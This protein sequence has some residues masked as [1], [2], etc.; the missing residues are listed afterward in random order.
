[1]SKITDVLEKGAVLVPSTSGFDLSSE[2]LFTAMCSDLVPVFIAQTLPNDRWS[3]GLLSQ[4]K[5]PPLATDFFGRVDINFE[6]FFVPYRLCYGG[7]EEFF[8]MP[9]LQHE[10]DTNH[11]GFRNP[12]DNVAG[13]AF[14]VGTMA[15]AD[16]SNGAIERN[17]SNNIDSQ[18]GNIAI[19]FRDANRLAVPDSVRPS[20][21]VN[22]VYNTLPKGTVTAADAGPGTLTDFM[23]AKISGTSITQMNIYNVLPYVAYHKIY[24]DYYRNSQYEN[25]AFVKPSNGTLSVEFKS[26]PYERFTTAQTINLSTS[27]CAD[28]WLVTKFRQRKWADDYFTTATPTPRGLANG[29]DVTIKTGTGASVSGSTVTPYNTGFTVPML[30]VANSLQMFL[31][32]ANISGWKYRD[33]IRAQW[34]VTPNDCCETAIYLGRYKTPVYNNSVAQ[35]VSATAGQSSY[36]TLPWADQLGNTA[37]TPSAGGSA[38]LFSNFHC[39]EHGVI[40]VLFSLVP[41]AYY[42]SGTSR[43]LNCKNIYDWADPLL[44]N[45]GTQAIYQWELCDID[46]TMRYNNIFGYTMPYADWCIRNDE[47]HGLLRNG[48]SLNQLVL[49]RSFGALSDPMANLSFNTIPHEAMDDVCAVSAKVSEYGCYGQI[50][51]NCKAIRP[52]QKFIIPTLGTPEFMR[53]EII[54]KGGT[55]ING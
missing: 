11:T 18:G 8:T 42:S 2:T 44:Q 36:S 4:I 32:R 34:G 38:N 14:G 37:C 7:A 5:L 6:A 43:M 55:K 31:E 52:L 26:L 17:P 51:W 54:G 40:M 39:K 9:K 47:V 13:R 21:F 25:P 46:N 22:D 3:L 12:V 24:S 41:H 28:G 48:Q 20:G 16:P 45:V 27:N 1:M 23:G 49:D 10:A 19:G 30:R 50:Y 15:Y 33:A 29:K 35:T 53:T